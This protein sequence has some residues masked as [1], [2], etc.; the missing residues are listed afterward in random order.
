MRFTCLLS[1]A[2]LLAWPAPKAPADTLPDNNPCPLLDRPD[3]DAITR[4][5]PW[6]ILPPKPAPWKGVT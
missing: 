6:R 5:R 3:V 2:F 1:L 4:V